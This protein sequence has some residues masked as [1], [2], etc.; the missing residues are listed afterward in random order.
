MATN[1][2]IKEDNNI[3]QMDCP[4]NETYS[5]LESMTI[6]QTSTELQLRAAPPDGSPIG[7]VPL[8]SPSVFSL[9]I[10]ITI[11]IIINRFRKKRHR[12]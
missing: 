1:N 2:T 3:F 12:L 10:P 6:Q 7:G 9:I 8:H 11:Y 4:S 5:E